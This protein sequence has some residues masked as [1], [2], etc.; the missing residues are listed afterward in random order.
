MVLEVGGWVFFESAFVSGKQMGDT[1]VEIAFILPYFAGKNSA[2]VP[3][4]KGEIVLQ[5]GGKEI[6]PTKSLFLSSW[7]LKSVKENLTVEQTQ[8]GK[9]HT[10][11]NDGVSVQEDQPNSLFEQFGAGT[12]SLIKKFEDL[13]PGTLV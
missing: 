13:N 4:G 11:D 2:I 8:D 12:S 7:S 9:I 10:Y 1:N 3:F 6:I 5:K